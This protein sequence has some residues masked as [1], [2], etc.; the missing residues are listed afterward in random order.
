M[1]LQIGRTQLNFCNSLIRGRGIAKA[2]IAFSIRQRKASHVDIRLSN[3]IEN[4]LKY[5]QS[6]LKRVVEVI[7]FWAVRGMFFSG[8]DEN[9]ALLEM[10]TTWDVW[11]YEPNLIPLSSN[12]VNVMLIKEVVVLRIYLELYAKSLF[13]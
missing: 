6:V 8:S 12:I 9:L 10:G 4:K 3:Q 13:I 5:W 7:K 1:A 11:N 2:F